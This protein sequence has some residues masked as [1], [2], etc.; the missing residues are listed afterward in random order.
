MNGRDKKRMDIMNSSIG[1]DIRQHTKCCSDKQSTLNKPSISRIDYS[2]VSTFR[3][4]ISG[5]MP[6]PITW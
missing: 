4:R 6:T 3:I 2:G 1:R 5:R